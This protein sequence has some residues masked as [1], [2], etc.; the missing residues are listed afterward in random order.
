MKNKGRKFEDKVQKTINSGA[1]WFDKG[2]L[3]S[4][5]YFIECKYTE[6]KGFRIT[7][8]MLEKLWNDALDS[9]KLPVIVIGIK[10]GNQKFVLKGKLEKEA[11]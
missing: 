1:F 10:N 5:E 9:N 3:K 6:K 7:T 4:D 11:I 8:K 2:D